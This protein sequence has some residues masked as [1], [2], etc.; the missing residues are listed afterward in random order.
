M[1]DTPSE[2]ALGG[3]VAFEVERTYRLSK[4]PELIQRV[5]RIG[6]SIA[7]VS[8]RKDLSYHF[9]VVRDKEVNAFSTPGGYVYIH[10]GLLEKANDNELACVIAHEVG[11]IAARHSVKKLQAV[12]GYNILMS[13]VLH[14][15][16]IEDLEQVMGIT[17]D[18]ISRGYSREDEL[19]ADKLA[20]RYAFGA[21]YDPYGMVTFLKKLEE[22]E[23]EA[24]WGV[25]GGIFS[26]HPSYVKRIKNIE[27]EIALLTGRKTEPIENAKPEE[28]EINHQYPAAMSSPKPI[29]FDGKKFCPTCGVKY[30]RWY[31]FCPK[32]GAELS[33][34]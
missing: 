14:E 11:H 15:A 7:S 33:Q 18:L 26:T 25:M 4:D 30:P 12:M 16:R 29:L 27:T 23:R 17:F 6:Q 24:H 34:K 1:I 20:V 22:I 10:T 8:D 3:K 28:N 21:G 9:K 5:E 2:V 31:N 19:L 32:D 13:F